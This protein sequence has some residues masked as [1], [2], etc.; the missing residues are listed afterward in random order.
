MNKDTE[1]PLSFHKLSSKE[2]LEGNINPAKKVSTEVKLSRKDSSFFIY[3]FQP[4]QSND[5]SGCAPIDLVFI[6][7]VLWFIYITFFKYLRKYVF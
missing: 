1:S 6:K 5:L 2:I 4:I 3:H 7:Y